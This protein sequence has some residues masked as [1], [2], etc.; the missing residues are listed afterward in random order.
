VIHPQVSVLIPCFNAEKYIGETLESVLRQ[1]WSATEIIVVDDGSIDG[2]SD[3]VRSFGQS[4][5]RL[6]EQANR[7]QTA[8]L[9]KCLEYAHGEF[10]Q[11]LDAD[12]VIE[13]EKIERQIKRLVDQPRCIASAEWGRFYESPTETKFAAESVWR[14]LAPLDWIVLSRA[15]GLGMMLPALWLIPMATIRVVGPWAEDLTLN[16]DAEYFTRVLL[17]SDRVL[18]CP[19]ARCHYRSGVQSSLSGRKSPRAWQSQYRVLELCESYVRAREDSERVRRAFSL[20]WQHLSHSC[21]PYDPELSARALARAREIH[22]VT[23][24]PDG[25]WAFKI[26]SQL[27]GWRVARKLQV[28]TGRP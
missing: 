25:G 20:S 19:G 21:Y 7:G 1:T 3:V 16:N 24:R 12:D 2:S 6:I 14:D 10:V 28:M 26:A 18:F 17:A 5:I 15:G 13:P 23:I 11:Y 4:K 8:A 9:N 22:T 27:V